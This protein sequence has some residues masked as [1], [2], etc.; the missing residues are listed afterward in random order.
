MAKTFVIRKVAYHYSDEHLYVH[1]LGGIE[2]VFDSEEKA[3]AA[4][5][6]L[7]RKALENVD[8]GDIEQLSGCS[9]DF[10]KEARAFKFFYKNRFDEDIVNVD[11]YGNLTCER[12]AKLPKGLTEKDVMDIRRT[13]GLKFHELTEYDSKP[14]FF[15]IWVNKENKFI[16]HIGATYFYN[17][18]AEALSNANSKIRELLNRSEFKGSLDEISTNPTFLKYVI[19]NSNQIEYD[20]SEQI[21]KTKYLQKHEEALALNELLKNKVFEIREIPLEQAAGFD[22]L[23]YEEM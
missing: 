21:L 13:L 18:Y 20:E 8:L 1:T 22:H 23:S 10:Y 11:E 5:I 17:S 7:E 16:E 14:V 2:K 15:G 3:K 6:N 12:G 4:F 9:L 19:Q